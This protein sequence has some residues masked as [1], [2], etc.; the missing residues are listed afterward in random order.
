MKKK[1]FLFLKIASSEE[2]NSS[3]LSQMKASQSEI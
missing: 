2:K 3:D 1:I